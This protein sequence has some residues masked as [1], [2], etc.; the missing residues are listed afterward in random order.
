[1]RHQT[2]IVNNQLLFASQSFSSRISLIRLASSSGG[3]LSQKNYCL[4]KTPGK[5]TRLAAATERPRN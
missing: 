1:M 2:E 4:K 5:K 3:S